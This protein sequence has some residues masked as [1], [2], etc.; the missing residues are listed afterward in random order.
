[1]TEIFACRRENLRRAMRE[2]G[3]DALLISQAANR[4]TFLALNC[5]ILSLTKVR[6][7]L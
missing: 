3:L 4:F 2:R 7:G 5:T 6:V 1:M